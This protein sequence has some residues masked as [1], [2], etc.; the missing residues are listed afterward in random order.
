MIA[1]VVTQPATVTLTRGDV[2]ST[3][4][5]SCCLDAEVAESVFVVVITRLVDCVS[6]AGKGTTETEVAQSTIAEHA[7]VRTRSLL[8]R[9][10]KT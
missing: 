1:T 2:A 6:T 7:V 8:T 9:V 3:P 5:C 4:N 10:A